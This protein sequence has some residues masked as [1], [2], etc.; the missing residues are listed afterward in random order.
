LF[1]DDFEDGDWAQ[2]DADTDGGRDNPDNDGWSLNINTTWPDAAGTGFGR[3][4]SLGAAGTDCTSTSGAP[5]TYMNCG[6]TLISGVGCTVNGNPN[7][8]DSTQGVFG[9]HWLS[10]NGPTTTVTDIYVRWYHKSLSG[11][12]PGHEKWLFLQDD[13]ASYQCCLL[14]R[15]GGG[16]QIALD[17]SNVEDPGLFG[18]NVS[19]LSMVDGRWYYI[20]VHIKMNSPHSTA[21]DVYELWM[22]DCGTDGTECTGTETLRAQYTDRDFQD[23]EDRAISTLWFENWGN[24][25]SHGEQ[26]YDQRVASKAFI[27]FADDGSG[28]APPDPSDTEKPSIVLN[29]AAVVVDDTQISLTWDASTDNT[30]VSHY[31]IESCVT[32]TCSYSVEG[33]TTGLAFT[34]TGLTAATQ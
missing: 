25:G 13:N 22:D 7:E 11:F 23:G 2:T 12:T 1:C 29:L 21:N 26:Y 32:A 28:G 34:V 6:Q 14:I 15:V 8:G 30:A 4:G 24:P 17:V 19:Q 3:C 18:Q 33:T 9:K 31:S 16:N 20:E 10:P 5:P 27:G